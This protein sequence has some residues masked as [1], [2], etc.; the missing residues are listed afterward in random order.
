MRYAWLVLWELRSSA[1]LHVPQFSRRLLVDFHYPAAL[2]LESDAWQIR[3]PQQV[4]REVHN[5]HLHPLDSSRP[6][7]IDSCKCKRHIKWKQLLA[8][9]QRKNS[10]WLHRLSF[11]FRAAQ[12]DS[13][14][15]DRSL[16]TELLSVSGQNLTRF[17]ALLPPAWDTVYWLWND[18]EDD[19][20]FWGMGHFQLF[21]GAFPF[22][23]FMSWRHFRQSY[24][25]CLQGQET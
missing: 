17:A 5:I 22:S 10:N 7:Y 8:S 4:H 9:Y 24:F 14:S 19:D 11:K 1:W 21:G 20:L 23:T 6:G 3:R 12:P 13:A 25:Q 18:F 16:S 15:D 2:P